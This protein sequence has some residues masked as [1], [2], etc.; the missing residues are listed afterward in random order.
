[1]SYQIQRYQ[2]KC[3]KAQLGLLY[4][5][6]TFG[7]L[8]LLVPHSRLCPSVRLASILTSGNPPAHVYVPPPQLP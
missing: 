1:M 6:H 7:A 5:R 2:I 8:L 3:F 4:L